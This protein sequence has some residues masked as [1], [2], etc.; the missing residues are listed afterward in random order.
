MYYTRPISTRRA[1]NFSMANKTETTKPMIQT[2]PPISSAASSSSAPPPPWTELPK[3]LT[4]NILQRLDAKQRLESAQKVC[5]TWWRV[6]KNPAMW[7]VIY[8]DRR[9]FA[10]A[11]QFECIF[12]GAVD[13]SQG[14][15]L[16]LKLSGFQGAALLH[17]AAQ[18]YNSSIAKSWLI[19][20]LFL[21]CNVF[22]HN[23]LYKI[24]VYVSIN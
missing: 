2:K 24:F 6:C 10:S 23:Q 4:E 14:Q 20:P 17:Y 15:L 3:D 11:D 12:R 19:N 13:R 21:R 22:K 7:R 9:D 5:S 18:R 8:L 16:D 1:K